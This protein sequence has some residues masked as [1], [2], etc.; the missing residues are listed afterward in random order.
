MYPIDHK[1]YMQSSY[2]DPEHNNVLDNLSA[3]DD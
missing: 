3:L 2:K 1:D